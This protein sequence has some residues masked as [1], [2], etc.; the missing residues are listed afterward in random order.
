MAQL[1]TCPALDLGLGHYAR[2]VALNSV[3]GSVMSVEPA[4]DSLSL[5]LSLS[6][7]H[8]LFLPPPHS[9]FSSPCP[10]VWLSH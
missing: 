2:I 6:L 3:L 8:S 4:W 7:S 10:P 9:A 5:S 1:V